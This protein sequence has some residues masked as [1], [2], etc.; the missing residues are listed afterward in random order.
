[1]ESNAGR[2]SM[3]SGNRT[4]ITGGNFTQINEHLE[5]H[6]ARN[7]LSQSIAKGA[8]HNSAERYDAPKCH[9]NTRVAIIE[10]IMYWVNS[11]LDSK[12]P[13]IKWLNGAA[14]AG[15]SAIMQTV[16]ATCA[17]EGTL[18]GSFF[19]KRSDYQRGVSTHLIS[20]LAYQLYQT[21]TEI[22]P[23]IETAV[24]LDPEFLSLSLPTQFT[25]LILNPLRAVVH[26]LKR[27][28]VIV[29]DG[30]DE[31]ND[32]K[33]QQ[34]II[35]LLLDI[36]CDSSSS[37]VPFR[38]LIASR[39]EPQIVSTFSS[40]SSSASTSLFT[41]INLIKNSFN[42]NDDIRLYMNAKFEVI[43]TK[44]DIPFGW[45]T[46]SDLDRILDLSSGQFIFSS[47]VVSYVDS[48]D[49]HPEGRL[50]EILHPGRIPYSTDENPFASLDALYSHIFLK[51]PQSHLTTIK[52][53]LPI[54]LNKQISG[55]WD[56][57]GRRYTT[58]P[59]VETQCPCGSRVLSE[60]VRNVE[61]V[62]G[63]AEGD[64]RVSLRRLS[65]VVSCE[66][67]DEIG[68]HQIQIHHASLG[69]FLNAEDRSGPFF[70]GD[71]HTQVQNHVNRVLRAALYPFLKDDTKHHDIHNTRFDHTNCEC[72]TKIQ[73]YRT[74][75][76]LHHLTDRP[77]PMQ[78][79]LRHSDIQI[80][81]QIDFAKVFDDASPINRIYRFMHI[82]YI[83]GYL[84]QQQQIGALIEPE[85]TALS[86]FNNFVG[87]QL[88]SNYCPTL[89][90]DNQAGDFLQVFL[91][92]KFLRTSISQYLEL[93]DFSCFRTPVIS[94]PSDPLFVDHLLALDESFKKLYAG[95]SALLSKCAQV[96]PPHPSWTCVISDPTYQS[97]LVH[98][99]L[100]LVAKELGFVIQRSEDSSRARAAGRRLYHE[101]ERVLV[102]LLPKAA[103][104]P[105]VM[106]LVRVFSCC[107]DSTNSHEGA[108]MIED[109]I[110]DYFSRHKYCDDTCRKARHDTLIE[111]IDHAWKDWNEDLKRHGPRC[112]QVIIPPLK[113]LIYIIQLLKLMSILRDF[114]RILTVY[115]IVSNLDMVVYDLARHF[116]PIAN[117]VIIARVWLR[118]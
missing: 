107:M 96:I 110:E 113:A 78:P 94:F 85:R 99:V 47:T 112:T 98:L 62:L 87:H 88:L 56:N 44:W 89:S 32:H 57:V 30:L 54:Y 103:F 31:C 108:P 75:I 58:S 53:I 50:K 29:I 43:R 28:I 52:T 116:I 117:F 16:A 69:D 80:F 6:N 12:Q 65:S 115:H 35:N 61:R 21:I 48:D 45:P 66:Y 73:H 71:P 46:E 60:D 15:K 8:R 49:H 82:A 68:G 38:F 17:N 23:H 33:V 22:R 41:E 24:D 13:K 109:A 84:W 70:L 64:M 100:W 11:P 59:F 79:L 9:P 26:Q 118:Y 92:V 101:V 37:S 40:A 19:F 67:S 5:L 20:T 81:S 25:N 3:F 74:H 86:A 114:M 90:N 36:S 55:L 18:G 91:N 93:L 77:N 1:M 83:A 76:L 14:G 106:L 104:S 97:K 4:M 95:Y 111:Q 2:V 7:V 51:V 10:E 63:L 34:H 105:E 27:L 72:A 42:V 39:R 102:K